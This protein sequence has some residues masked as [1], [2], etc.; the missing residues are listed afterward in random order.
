MAAGIIGQTQIANAVRTYIA[1]VDMFNEHGT[2]MR[3]C[4]DSKTL[5]RKQGRA[6][7]E[8]Y[9]PPVT[10]TSLTDG[11][12][13]DSPT[14]ISDAKITITPAEVGVQM[15]WTKRSDATS[16]LNMASIV[17]ELTANA[18]NY[19]EDTDLLGQ[20]DSFS[21]S[22]GSGTSTLTV[23]LVGKGAALVRGGRTGTSRTGARTTGDPAPPPYFAI[24]HEYNR[25]DLASQ[26][27]G[28]GG[29]PTQVTTGAAVS[30]FAGQS[31]TEFNARFIEQH[32]VGNIHGVKCL[33]DNNFTI[34]S[35]AIKGG[36]FSKKAMVH[37]QFAGMD[38]YQVTEKDG[39]AIR[40]TVTKDYGFGERADNYG[41][42]LHVDCTVPS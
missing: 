12:E 35:N 9:V 27:S 25:Y 18:I 28:L 41:V 37:V 5:S 4:I 22:L 39:R 40:V 10:A 6:W 26:L 24:F 14:Q 32:V 33:V 38:S 30:N 36:V 2:V 7:N 31:L 34:S 3:Q 21:S 15:L 20:L 8:P 19:K 16:T 13:F 11:V 1:E 29:A 23:D 17:A 42:E